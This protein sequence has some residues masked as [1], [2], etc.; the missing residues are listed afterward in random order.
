MALSSINVSDPSIRITICPPGEKS[1]HTTLGSG[2][3]GIN[4]KIWYHN[5]SIHVEW[6]P[7]ELK[8]RV[9]VFDSACSAN[10]SKTFE[11]LDIIVQTLYEA[12]A[13]SCMQ[14]TTSTFF[15]VKFYSANS[16]HLQFL[17]SQL[18]KG[19]SIIASADL[20][21]QGGQPIAH[22]GGVVREDG[23]PAN[24]TTLVIDV[25]MGIFLP[26]IRLQF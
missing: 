14:C 15:E 4:D 2:K 1:M 12:T 19:G 26:K 3:Y 9:R 6:L 13:S 22:R 8:F 25:W 17:Y 18:P 10:A 5:D 21:G 23:A 24:E 11:A 16:N 20:P 7:D